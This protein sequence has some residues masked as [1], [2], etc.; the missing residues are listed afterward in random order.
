MCRSRAL[1]RRPGVDDDADVAA[2]HVHVPRDAVDRERPVGA[3]MHDVVVAVTLAR[4]QKASRA[5][6][7]KDEL[8]SLRRCAS[9][10]SRVQRGPFVP[11]GH[12]ALPAPRAAS[13]LRVAWQWGQAEAD[14]RAV[15]SDAV[16]EVV[17]HP[18]R[19]RARADA[20]PAPARQR[21]VAPARH[22]GGEPLRRAE[23][24]WASGEARSKPR[25]GPPKQVQ[26][27]AAGGAV[28][29]GGCRRP[30][31]R[32]PRTGSR[33]APAPGGRA[34]SRR[35][36]PTRRA[37]DR[38]RGRSSGSRRTRSPSA[39]TAASASVIVRVPPWPPRVGGAEPSRCRRARLSRPRPRSSPSTP[40]AAAVPGR[41][42]AATRGPASRGTS[43]L[44]R[45]PRRSASRAAARRARSSVRKAQ[46]RPPCGSRRTSRGR[47]GRRVRNPR[48]RLRAVA[49]RRHDGER[50]H[51]RERGDEECPAHGLTLVLPR[52]GRASSTPCRRPPRRSGRGHVRARARRGAGAPLRRR[53]PRRA[54]P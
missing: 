38:D 42:T 20:D 53:P 43:V 46:S 5:S 21:V 16:R 45:R 8:V 30:A 34:R 29:A 37:S 48:R 1:V 32:R 4:P 40:S 41:G 27:R 15:R 11:A 25:F 54:R 47:S 22:P 19:P 39:C 13:S 3:L 35:R 26:P 23:P 44:S 52:P 31:P 49:G 18:S 24:Q 12:G 36:S 28:E 50:E 9:A 51:R 7:R 10:A 33:G 6:G 14:A 2:A 17:V